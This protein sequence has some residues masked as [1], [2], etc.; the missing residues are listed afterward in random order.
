MSKRYSLVFAGLGILC[1]V[2]PAAAWEHHPLITW[3]VVETMPQ[4]GGAAPARAVPLQEFLIAEE[5][6][7]ADLLAVH[8]A[9]A[10]S[11]LRWYAACP[12]VLA[13]KVTGNPND[14]CNRFFR[15]IRVNPAIKTPL[16]TTRLAGQEFGGKN[17]L[18]PDAV[19]ILSNTSMLEAFVFEELQPGELVH[20]VDIVSGA[21]NEPDYG[22]DVGLFSDNGTSI[23]RVFGFGAQPFG[24]PNLDYGSQ[25]PFHMGFFHESPIIY[26]F[27]GFLKQSFVE[28]RIHLFKALSEYAFSKGQDY[29]GWRFM[30]WGLH[31]IGDLAMPYHTT[32]LPRYSTLHMLWI[33]LLD[34]IG[35]SKYKNNAVQLV[36]NRHMA[37]ELFQGFTM[38][39]ACR[40]NDFTNPSIAALRRER[41]VPV[42]ADDLPRNALAKASHG[43]SAKIDKAVENYM[44]AHFVKNPAVELANCPNRFNVVEMV[45]AEHG[46]A[47]IETI[48]RLQAE[49]LDLFG[50]YGRSYALAIVNSR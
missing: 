20:P 34:M 28:Y 23:G 22:M 42:Y 48:A 21:S 12:D 43:L 40:N 38:A 18:P 8:E 14:V 13:F 7:L 6:G 50:T 39:D 45:Q 24:N 29:W 32:V 35:L 3:H 5:A 16:Y 47:A 10:K 11:N 41:T 27:A 33:N 2:W 26:L 44:P 49:A 4:I 37:L 25:A 17:V 30:G 1:A 31:Y 36:S 15:A 9:W 46:D 19:S